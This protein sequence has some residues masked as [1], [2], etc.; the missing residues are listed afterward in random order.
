ML[1]TVALN[2][3]RT[4]ILPGLLCFVAPIVTL[5]VIVAISVIV[6]NAPQDTFR[7]PDENAGQLFTKTLAET[8]RLDYS[9]DY[10]S[11]DVENLLHPRGALTHDGRAVPFGFLGLPVVYAPF[12]KLLGGDVRYIAI[13]LSVLATVALASAG[14][15]LVPERPWLAW[16][17]VLSVS[18]LIYFFNR[19]FLNALPAT[20]FECVAAYFVV[21]YF[22]SGSGARR[23]LVWASVAFALAAFMRY[24]LAIFQTLFVTVMVLHKRGTAWRSV[25]GDLS[26]YVAPT[27][28]LFVVPVFALNQYVYGSPFTYGYGLFNEAYFPNRVATGDFPGNVPEQMRSVL[29]PSYPFDLGV[30]GSSLVHQAIGIAPSFVAVCCLGLA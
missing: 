5:G 9:A 27:L 26:A 16:L 14:A 23:E 25:M 17:A 2:K 7:S 13:G 20:A 11:N 21:R 18:P 22:Q 24:E 3:P 6:L 10:L 1:A 8:G 12:Y 30:A 28:L 19:P 4:G 15:R 29:M